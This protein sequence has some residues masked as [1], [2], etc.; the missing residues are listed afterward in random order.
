MG[1]YFLDTQYNILAFL[2]TIKVK[3]FTVRFVL[4]RMNFCKFVAGF[5]NNPPGHSN[6]FCAQPGDS[7]NFL[8]FF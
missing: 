5:V 2:L 4:D 6:D 1:H 7:Q 3:N 8:S